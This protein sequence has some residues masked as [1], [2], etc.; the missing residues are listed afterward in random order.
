[1]TGTMRRRSAAILGVSMLLL[2]ACSATPVGSPSPAAVAPS[3]SASAGAIATTSRTPRPSPRATPSPSSVPAYESPDKPVDPTPEPE[4]AVDDDPV[5]PDATRTPVPPPPAGSLMVDWTTASVRG[6]EEAEGLRSYGA[7]GSTWLITGDVDRTIGD[8]DT[9][10]HGIIWRSERGSAWEPVLDVKDGAIT[11]VAPRGSGFVAVGINGYDDAGVWLSDDGRAWRAVDDDAFRDGRMFHVG[12]TANGI[13]AFGEAGS[14]DVGVIW[15]S[16][17][18]EEWLRATNPSGL[19]VARGLRALVQDDGRLTAFVGPDY[20]TPGSIDVWSTTG[21]AEWQKVATLP[22]SDDANVSSAAHGP[23]GWVAVGHS[24]RHSFGPGVAW[25]SEDGTRWERLATGPD[26]FMALLADESGFIATGFV[27]GP[28]GDTCGDPRD[29]QAETW[30]STDGG[31]WRQMPADDAFD[32]SAVT[33]MFRDGRRLV[34]Y[35]PAFD[36][37]GGTDVASWTATLPGRSV[38]DAPPSDPSAAEQ[39]CGD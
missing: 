18:G 17:D 12:V 21:R 6:L 5:L 35:G 8:G 19:R 13:V 29:F 36:D 14:S 20:G 3:R 33:A 24:K 23:L 22:R 11:N 38:D 30:T 25:R 39:G 16:P 9:D 32:L 37:S 1:M 2:A 4:S 34:G 7:N 10:R 27:G 31:V 28:P 26:T 15:T